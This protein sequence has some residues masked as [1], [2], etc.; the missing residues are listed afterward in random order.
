[1]ASVWGS[2][3]LRQHLYGACVS[4]VNI[5]DNGRY[6]ACRMRSTGREVFL[7]RRSKLLSI[8]VVGKTK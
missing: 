4:D 1:M 5:L 7:S 2:K 6:T 8:P 3:T